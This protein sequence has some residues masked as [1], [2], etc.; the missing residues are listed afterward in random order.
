MLTSGVHSQPA[1]LQAFSEEQSV[2]CSLVRLGQS[3]HKDSH[4]AGRKR[5]T[6][7]RVGAREMRV[8]EKEKSA[9]KSC[10][11]VSLW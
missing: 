1:T 6:S 7:E 5:R 8:K 9:L 10:S 4:P 2:Q 3:G 11:E